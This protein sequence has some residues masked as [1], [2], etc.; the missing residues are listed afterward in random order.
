MRPAVVVGPVGQVVAVGVRV[1]EE[2]AMLDDE[3]SEFR[4][5]RDRLQR[6]KKAAGKK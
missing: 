3:L 2:A 6:K 5:H 4:L 1:V